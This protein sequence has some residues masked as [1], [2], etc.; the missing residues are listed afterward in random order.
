MGFL[1]NRIAQRQRERE[2]VKNNEQICD[3]QART[4][5]MLERQYAAGEI[6]ER[7]YRQRYGVYAQQIREMGR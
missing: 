3:Y 5:G 7:E 2:T 1:Q 6:S 4:I